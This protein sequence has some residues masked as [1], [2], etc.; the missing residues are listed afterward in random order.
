MR[1]VT[2]VWILLTC[3][4]IVPAKGFGAD[5]AK[6]GIIDFQRVLETSDAGKTA[7]ARINE[8]GKKMETDLKTKGA[9][10]EELRRKLEREAL[11]MSKEMREEKERQIRININDLKAMQAKYINEFKAKETQLIQGI[12]EEVFKLVENIGD[13]E[14]FLLI[15]EKREAGVV[16]GPN[17]IDL[18]DRIIQ[19]Y[20]AEYAQRGETGKSQRDE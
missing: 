8:R 11:V 17:T 13:K 5:V 18:T 4:T 15:L 16:Y 6:I 9:E 19:L 2:L 1:H 14:G 10:I 20:N 7:Q 12:Q 3:L